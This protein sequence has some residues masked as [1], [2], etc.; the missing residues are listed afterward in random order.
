M[1]PAKRIPINQL[2]QEEGASALA[3]SPDM[4]PYLNYIMAS[5]KGADLTSHLEALSNLPLET[6]YVHKRAEALYATARAG[7]KSG[8]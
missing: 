5:M 8:A 2:R 3:S 4:E 7:L 6:R 1:D